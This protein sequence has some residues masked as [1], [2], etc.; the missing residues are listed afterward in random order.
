MGHRVLRNYTYTTSESPTSN[1][2]LD[3]Q[4]LLK[5]LGEYPGNDDDILESWDTS[6]VGKPEFSVL[7]SS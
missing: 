5:A 3:H 6:T 2:R 4:T 7:R 1:D